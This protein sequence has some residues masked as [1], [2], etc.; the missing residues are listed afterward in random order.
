MSDIRLKSNGDCFYS[1]PG[2]IIIKGGVSECVTVANI[3]MS[4]SWLYPADGLR[5]SFSEKTFQGRHLLI[6]QHLARTPPRKLSD[7]FLNLAFT[8]V[9][10]KARSVIDF[11]GGFFDS[12]TFTLSLPL[13]SSRGAVE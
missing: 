11:S 1:C 9:R 4:L 6:Q 3:T 13:S 7:S 10:E 12:W 8:D 2:C 5:G